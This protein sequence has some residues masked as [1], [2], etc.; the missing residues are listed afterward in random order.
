MHAA[1]ADTRAC[2]L[3]ELHARLHVMH[4]VGPLPHAVR[5]LDFL[6]VSAVHLALC[7]WTVLPPGSPKFLHE[8]IANQSPLQGTRDVSSAPPPAIQK[9][10]DSTCVPSRSR[11]IPG[12]KCFGGLRRVHD[13]IHGST[14]ANTMTCRSSGSL[15]PAPRASVPE[16]CPQTPPRSIHHEILVPPARPAFAHRHSTVI[17]THSANPSPVPRPCPFL[18][19]RAAALA[20]TTNSPP[21]TYPSYPRRVVHAPGP[22]PTPSPSNMAFPSTLKP[23]LIS[24]SISHP[25]FSSLYTI[26]RI[27]IDPLHSLLSSQNPAIQI[28]SLRSSQRHH[29]H[30]H[31]HPYYHN[32]QTHAVVH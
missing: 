27:S 25:P 13:N 19:T 5:G 18:V 8:S 21:R 30:H 31:H 11:S 12:S 20:L 23:R 4:A 32:R 15:S 26:A 29:H 2:N 22:H 9:I 24:S 7:W 17:P 6:Q 3:D 16:T 14:E 28:P 10:V 1:N